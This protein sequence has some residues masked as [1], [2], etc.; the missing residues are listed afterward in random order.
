MRQF[1]PT[2][3]TDGEYFMT[4]HCN[5]C[6][7][8]DPD[9]RRNLKSCHILTKSFFA[10]VIEW[11]YNEDNAP[12]CTDYKY[13]DWDEGQPDAIDPNQLELFKQDNND[14]S[15]QTIYHQSTNQTT[16]NQPN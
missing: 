7:N 9:D 11:V 15:N 10:P 3:G 14:T 5:H 4:H 12:S 1:Y 2:N 16:C 6:V 8:H 13:H